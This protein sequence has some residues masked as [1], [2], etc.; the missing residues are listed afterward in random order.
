MAKILELTTPDEIRAVFGVSDDELSD[1]ILNLPIFESLWQMELATVYEGLPA[2]IDDIKARYDQ[3]PDSA[4]SI[5]KQ[6]LE[7]VKVFSAYATS[8]LFLANAQM[9]T[10]K[11]VTDGRAEV[12]RFADSVAGLMD[13]LSAMYRRLLARIRYLLR[14]LGFD[15]PEPTV[16]VALFASAGLAVNPITDE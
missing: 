12:E 2:L 8:K 5:E 13:G 7:T 14:L 11:R 10:P 3:D 1:N 6:L 16:G 9:F 15:V 4:T